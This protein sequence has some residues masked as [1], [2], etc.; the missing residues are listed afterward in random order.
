MTINQQYGIF[1]GVL[2]GILLLIIVGAGVG[3]YNK[4]KFLKDN[5]CVEQ[6]RVK[7]GER[8][9]CG[10]ACYRDQ[11]KVVY[12]CSFGEKVELQ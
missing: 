5:N 10:K 1:M 9:Y 6:S 4:A 7:T 8:V 2:I 11:E 3:A 12:K